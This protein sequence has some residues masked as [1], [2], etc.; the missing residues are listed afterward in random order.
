MAKSSL[1]LNPVKI[2]LDKF[3]ISLPPL[4]VS[5]PTHAA[6]RTALLQL[7]AIIGLAV[8]TH[9]SIANPVVA[10]FAL[11]VFILKTA[12]IWRRKRTPPRL[13]MML[14]TILSLGMVVFFYGG[15][16]GQTAGISFLVLLVSLKFL[17]SRS[18]RDYYIVCIILYFLAAS[19]FLFDS[20]IISIFVVVLYTIAITTI[21]F[22][23]SNPTPTKTVDSIKASSMII[24]KSL[25]LALILFF[26][27]PRISGDFGF[28]PSQDESRGNTLNDSLVAGDLSSNAF[29]TELAFRVEFE[30]PV[31]DRSQLYWRSKTMPIERTFAWEVLPPSPADFKSAKVKQNAANIDSGQVAYKILHEPSTDSFLPYLDYVAGYSKGVILD[32][33]SVY[34]RRPNNR[35]IRYYGASTFSPSLPKTNQAGSPKLVSTE[36]R[37]TARLLSLLSE[38]RNNAS[39]NEELVDIVYQYFVDNQ[40][41]YSLEPPL[42]DDFTPLD[43]FIFNTKTGYC[44][45]FASAFTILMRWLGIPSRIVVGYQGGVLNNTGNYLEVRYSD[46]HAWSEVWVNDQWQ[47][48]DPTATVS[49]ERIE[50][51]MDALLELWDGGF[52]NRGRSGRALSNY[53]NPTG[54]ARYARKISETWKNIGYQWNKWIVDYDKETQQELL[55]KMGFNASNNAYILVIIMIVCAGVLML[56]YFWQLIP[57]AVRRE[58]LQR[59]YLRFTNKFKKHNI[60][61]ELAD[62]PSEFAKKALVHF[63]QHAKEIDL[64]TEQYQQLRYGRNR[65]FKQQVKQF[66]LTVENSSTE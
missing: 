29:S 61:K 35:L 20:S 27:F 66:K 64:I 3:N 19:T 65:L 36:S 16:N 11:I 54:M 5:P 47:R 22:R 60:I 13:F 21:L 14:L 15:W 55:E 32:D 1:T 12:I 2:L 53:L 30:G 10:V 59:S 40:F 43:D 9:F 63:P 33:Y 51:G 45:H 6:D 18:L 50:F 52:L 4:P 56:F 8:S 46:A 58:E 26:F 37:P 44:E 28:L 23:I 17:E 57:K 41:N 62:T 31:P 48:V 34:N 24:A 38:F 25:P 42:L 39:T 7:A 49:P